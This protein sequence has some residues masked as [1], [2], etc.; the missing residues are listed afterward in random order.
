MIW[1]HDLLHLFYIAF[2]MWC[3]RLLSAT[4]P[5][6]SLNLWCH[7]NTFD[8]VCSP[9]PIWSICRIPP[10]IF[11][12]TDK[13][14]YHLTA[15]GDIFPHFKILYAVCSPLGLAT[16]TSL[17]ATEHNSIV[18]KRLECQDTNK[19]ATPYLSQYCCV[20]FCHGNFWSYHVWSP[21]HTYLVH[22]CQSIQH[23]CHLQNQQ[24]TCPFVL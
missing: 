11:P 13:M 22:W 12:I 2:V 9:Y 5:G 19:Q 1:V 17:T 3:C 23:G 10:V 15:Q 18:C 16:H 21:T 14:W 6:P 24:G 20:S 7:S 4:E 8:S